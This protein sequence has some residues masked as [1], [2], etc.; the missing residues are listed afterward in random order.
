MNDFAKTNEAILTLTG[1]NL[2]NDGDKFRQR[3]I[4]Q[5]GNIPDFLML[6]IDIKYRGM[7]VQLKN[8]N[9]IIT[10]DEEFRITEHKL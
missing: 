7:V 10:L 4:D 1:A 5:T 2:L 6:P 9:G 8:T 3:H